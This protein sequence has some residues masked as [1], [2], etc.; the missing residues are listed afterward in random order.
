MHQDA[1]FIENDRLRPIWRCFLAVVLLF[2][3][4]VFTL[5]VL[6]TVFAIQD[7]HSSVMVV[8]FWQSLI[9]LVATLASYKLMTAIFD[10][11]PLGSVGLAFHPR[12]WRELVR[13]LGV[14]AAMLSLVV[15][16]EGMG[17][18]AHF[19]FSPHPM[20]K[21]GATSFVMFAVAAAHEEAV[22][23]GYPFQRLVESLTPVGA[24]AVTSM[25]FGLAHLGNPHRTWISTLNTALVG[26]PFAIAYLRT[27]SLWM[28]IGMHFIWNYLMDFLLG[29]PVSGLNMAPSI[30]TAHVRGPAWLTGGAYGPEGGLL[31]M[32]AI[33]VVTAYLSL[34]KSIYIS[35]EMRALVF[36]PV[37]SDWPETP[38]TIF[39]APPDEGAK[40]D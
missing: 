25:L 16:L 4:S 7:V 8:A 24:I 17:G 26:I 38:I 35:E 36:T 22:F 9:G 1:I 14:G 31:A 10:R 23:R 30:L 37:T 21:V 19:T 11:R 40:R 29:L 5:E 20:L 15:A 3:V 28:P 12:W 2:A 32:G 33:L 13:G 18:L 34:T 6:E 39:S 27:R